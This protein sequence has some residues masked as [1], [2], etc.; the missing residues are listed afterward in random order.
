V[1]SV[2]HETVAPQVSPQYEEHRAP[3]RAPIRAATK[4]RVWRALDP[5]AKPRACFPFSAPDVFRK[6]PFRFA[7]PVPFL[8][9]QPAD[10]PSTRSSLPTAAEVGISLAQK[11]SAPASPP[12]HCSLREAIPV[13]VEARA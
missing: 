5:R 7:V 9:P 6:E 11:L 1:V 2:V 12:G 10:A 13:E 3:V 8:N 4:L